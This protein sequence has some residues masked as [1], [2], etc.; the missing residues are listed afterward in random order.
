MVNNCVRCG[1]RVRPGENW[2]KVQLWAIKGIFDWGCFI[3]LLK[4]HYETCATA[5]LAG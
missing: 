5:G 3:T 2:V 1:R 4:S